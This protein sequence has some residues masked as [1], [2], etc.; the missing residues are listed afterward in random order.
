RGIGAAAAMGQVRSAVRALASTGLAPGPLLDALDRYARAHGVG[1]MT[2]LVHAE[3]DV[4]SRRLRF[5]CAG[6]LPPVVIAPDGP[7]RSLWDGRSL[8]LDAWHAVGA[9]RPQ[10]ELE[11]APGSTLVLYTDGLVERHRESIDAGIARLLDA[12]AAHGYGGPAE[13]ADRLM[14]TLRDPASTDDACLLV[15]RLS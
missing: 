10:A 7:P 12:I 6:H 1:R 5:A 13:L 2:T 14:R 8:P 11:L 15:T 3:L 4:R 9:T